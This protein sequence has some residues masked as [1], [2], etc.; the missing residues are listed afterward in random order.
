M[1]T[2]VC[3]EIGYALPLLPN[4]LPV[5]HFYTNRKWWEV[6]TGY[7]SLGLRPGGDWVNTLD[8]TFYSFLF[9][10]EVVAAAVLSTFS[11]LTHSSR[12]LLLEI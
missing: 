9:K 12:R 2:S 4:I 6:L 7:L 3:I 8:K 10:Q 1:D 5:E 11:S